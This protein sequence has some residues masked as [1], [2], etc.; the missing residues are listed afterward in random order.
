MKLVTAILRPGQ[1]EEVT[2]AAVNAG[3]H[4]LTADE[5]RGFGQ[6]YGYLASTG[7]PRGHE[8][9]VVPKLRVNILVQDETAEHIVDAMAKAMNSGG[10]GAGKI[11]VTPVESVLRVRTGDRDRDAV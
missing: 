9:M 11:W 5:V 6:Q 2:Q 8:A 10:I 4:G 7:E 1:F 3:A